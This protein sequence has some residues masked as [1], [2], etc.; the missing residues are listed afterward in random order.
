M[1][2]SVQADFA[3]LAARSHPL[4]KLGFQVCA[5]RLNTLFFVILGFEDK[6]SLYW[7]SACSKLQPCP[8]CLPYE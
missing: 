8:V 2:H 1:K 5:T 3:Q 7:A 6:V 4:Q